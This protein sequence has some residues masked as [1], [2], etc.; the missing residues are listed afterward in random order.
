MPDPPFPAPP[1]PRTP[2]IGRERELA[3]LDDLIRRDDVP[4]LV[5]T[6]PG[7]VGKTRLALQLAA[8]LAAASADR[9]A[10][11]DLTPIRDPDLIAAAIA[12]RLGLPDDDRVGA[13]A[14]LHAYFRGRDFLLVLDNLEQVAEAAPLLAELL[15]ACPGLTILVTSRA[16]LR[17]SIERTFPVEPLAL[18]EVSGAVPVE[19][20]ARAAAVRLFVERAQQSNPRSP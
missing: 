5:L 19:D 15:A 7:G 18:A 11:V 6:G 4:L 13:A 20:V 9:V 12:Q 10:F 8:D 14:R 1:R 16:R 2:L 3:A 17:L